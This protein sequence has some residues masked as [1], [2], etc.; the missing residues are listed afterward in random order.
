[1]YFPQ[2]KFQCTFD[3]MYAFPPQ[4]EPIFKTLV[5]NLAGKFE[6]SDLLAATPFFN[7]IMLTFV[8]GP[9]EDLKRRGN[10]ID[11]DSKL[12]LCVRVS[13]DLLWDAADNNHMDK[14]VHRIIKAILLPLF[15]KH[16]V[17]TA[18]LETED[19]L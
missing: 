5:H 4:I 6:Q 7:G 18:F 11:K 13:G 14:E 16:N 17:D 9:K 10:K 12:W 15:T 1:M 8:V 3:S 19:F 2:D